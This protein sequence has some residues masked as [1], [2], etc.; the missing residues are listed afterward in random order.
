MDHADGSFF[1]AP[2]TSLSFD[3]A[4]DKP[5]HDG[6]PPARAV[7]GRRRRDTVQSQALQLFCTRSLLQAQF[8]RPAR[9]VPDENAS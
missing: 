8:S 5:P 4:T 7:T 3:R 1:F 2:A 6:R 9:E